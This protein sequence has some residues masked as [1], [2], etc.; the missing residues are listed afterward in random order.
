MRILFF[1]LSC[2]LAWAAPTCQFVAPTN[3]ATS[4]NFTIQ[5]GVTSISL[6]N[7]STTSG[8]AL[9][10]VWTAKATND[11]TTIPLVLSNPSYWTALSPPLA[12]G[13]QV[14]SSPTSATPTITV[15]AGGVFPATNKA[16][17]GAYQYQLAVTDN[18]GTSTCSIKVGVVDSTPQ[19]TVNYDQSTLGKVSKLLL[20]PITDINHLPWA[21]MSSNSIGEPFYGALLIQKLAG[22]ST[23]GSW[24][25]TDPWNTAQAGTITVFGGTVNTSGT[26]VTFVSG[27]NFEGL[28]SGNIIYINKSLTCTLASTPITPFTTAACTTSMG[29]LNGVSYGS[30]SIVGK[31]TAF[32]TTFCSAGT[33]LSVVTDIVIWYPILSGF[34]GTTGRALGNV[35]ACQDD[36]HLT[37]ALS[38]AFN[39]GNADWETDAYIGSGSGLSYAY[40]EGDA[41]APGPG[42]NNSCNNIGGPFA[43]N[44]AVIWYFGGAPANFYDSAKALY[45]MWWQTGIDDYLM[46]ARA[47]SDRW[48]NSTRIDKG[49]AFD[50]IGGS[51]RTGLPVQNLYLGLSGIFLRNADNPPYDYGPG[52]RAAARYVTN[53]GTPVNSLAPGC[54]NQASPGANNCGQDVRYNGYAL[55]YAAMDYLANSG[56]NGAS[57]DVTT[58]ASDILAIKNDI[59]LRWAICQGT[60]FGYN[61][62]PSLP[63]QGVC[64]QNDYLGNGSAYSSWGQSSGAGTVTLTNGSSVVTLAGGTF[65]A[66]QFAAPLTVT[67]VSVPGS[68][69]ATTTATQA[70]IG[71]NQIVVASITGI[72]GGQI[73]VAAG[74]PIQAVVTGISGS[75]ITLSVTTTAVLSSTAINFYTPPVFT[76]SST[77]L[78]SGGVGGGKGIAVWVSGATGSGCSAL[79]SSVSGA[80]YPTVISGTTFSVPIASLGCSYTASSATALSQNMIW[81]TSTGSAIP[82]WPSDGDNTWYYATRTDATHL[83]LNDGTGAATPYLGSLTSGAGWQTVN[84]ASFNNVQAI[85]GFFWQ[86]YMMGIQQYAYLMAYYALLANN[87][88]GDAA[89]AAQLKGWIAQNAHVMAFELNTAQQ[90]TLGLFGPLATT[91]G[92]Y[93]EIGFGCPGPGAAVQYVSLRASSS[94]GPCDLG[95]DGDRQLNGEAAWSCM[96]AL[97]LDPSNGEARS[98]VITMMGALYGGPG[99]PGYAAYNESAQFLN[100]SGQFQFYT[101]SNAQKLIG[102]MFGQGGNMSAWA[103]LRITP[104]QPGSGI[105]VGIAE[106]D[107][108]HWMRQKR[109]LSQKRGSLVL[110]TPQAITAGIQVGIP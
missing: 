68:A 8:G 47:L 63:G 14:I 53:V 80:F 11:A 30:R 104:R 83:Q 32:N 61:D 78:L 75:T 15:A 107:V 56:P 67:A 50:S 51:T 37:A 71:S 3:P 1:L 27:Q 96:A 49:L 7:A 31:G 2:S 65:S 23:V 69:S 18:N 24:W 97:L 76:V 82:H 74:I 26:A 90:A 17:T 89:A 59:T 86:P 43:A 21:S 42:G 98:C 103:I 95:I 41:L 19:G 38:G 36:T 6:P 92:V 64:Q 85:L 12:P 77:A 99:E 70:V 66:A 9:S 101:G 13:A 109:M 45:A 106:A 35:L 73:A 46:A 25:M 91:N 81:F 62:I 52:L 94:D 57:P 88:S 87:G 29:T 34:N 44:C 60:S 72:A 48:W 20:G 28:L 93:Y 33:P 79:N 58:A 16:N 102:Q 100:P 39:N 105:S 54:N 108:A 22:V 84:P 10:Y 40:I 5:Y 110:Q 55:Q 4:A